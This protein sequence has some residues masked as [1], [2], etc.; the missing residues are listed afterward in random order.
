MIEN[1]EIE[2]PEE[3]ENKTWK[4]ITSR[5]IVSEFSSKIAQSKKEKLSE[6]KI[7]KDVRKNRHEENLTKNIYQIQK[8]VLNKEKELKTALTKS[9]RDKIYGYLNTLKTI[10]KENNYSDANVVESVLK[11]INTLIFNTNKS[12]EGK[13]RSGFSERKQCLNR[14]N[15]N[16]VKSQKGLVI[17]QKLNQLKFQV[18][19]PQM[20]ENE[21]DG[22]LSVLKS[23]QKDIESN[24]STFTGLDNIPGRLDQIEQYKTKLSNM[25]FNQSIKKTDRPTNEP[26]KRKM[27][28]IWEFGL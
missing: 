11:K 18:K 25:S 19:N 16:A 9:R 8:Y 26:K 5:K 7:E 6:K 3:Q 27:K 20:T 4:K 12:V 1:I 22:L 2:F 17:E 15:N 23:L 28:V 14:I 10:V 24:M 13:S 21:R